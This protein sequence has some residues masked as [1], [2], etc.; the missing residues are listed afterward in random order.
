MK[1]LLLLMPIIIS[2]KIGLSDD[3]LNELNEHMIKV[4]FEIEF[5]SNLPL[6]FIKFDEFNAEKAD[7]LEQAHKAMGDLDA[8]PS[9]AFDEVT[10]YDEIVIENMF[11][12][13]L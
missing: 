3:W 7:A 9:D 10:L 6:L 1:V 12:D 13:E 2:E 11:N 8:L 4:P 5:T